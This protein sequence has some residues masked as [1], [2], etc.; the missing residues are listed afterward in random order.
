MSAFYFKLI[1]L[2][3]SALLVAL[4]LR[5]HERYWDLGF[6][7]WRRVYAGLAV[8]FLGTLLGLLFEFA[9]IK[10]LQDRLGWPLDWLLFGA[11]TLVGAWLILSGSFERLARLQGER[12]NLDRERESYE[13]INAI[14]E[15]ANGSYSLVEILDYS[16]KEFIGATEA[17]A[18]VVWL[19]HH[20]NNE[21]ILASS[22]GLP[23][24]VQQQSERI[25]GDDVQFTRILEHGRARAVQGSESVRALLPGGDQLRRYEYALAFPMINPTVSE[26][27]TPILGL[28]ILFASIPF[29]STPPKK[30]LYEAALTFL[31]RCIERSFLKRMLR[32]RDERQKDNQHVLEQFSH[33]LSAWSVERNPQRQLRLAISGLAEHTPHFIG[34]SR[35]HVDDDRWEP[36]AMAGGAKL[37]SLLGDPAM[38]DAAAKTVAELSEQEFLPATSA[39]D[40]APAVRYRLI[41][42]GIDL[43]GKSAQGI[44]F[45]PRED[46]LPFWWQWAETIICSLA[47]MAFTKEPQSKGLSMGMDLPISSTTKPQSSPT[48]PITKTES[49]FAKETE[50]TPARRQQLDQAMLTWLANQDPPRQLGRIDFSADIPALF[51][52]DCAQFYE[53]LWWALATFDSN[54][55][56]GDTIVDLQYDHGHLTV[57]LALAH[58]E[59]L[60]PA[61]RLPAASPLEPTDPGVREIMQVWRGRARVYSAANGIVRLLLSITPPPATDQ[62]A[63][64]TLPFSILVVDEE[65]LIRDLLVGMV[66][67]LGHR[68]SPT[69]SAATGLREF[70]TDHFDVLIVSQK[71]AAKGK[72]DIV[73]QVHEFNP[74]TKVIVIREQGVLDKSPVPGAQAT[75]LKPFRLEDLRSVL[76]D[77]LLGR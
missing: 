59:S 39:A 2:V 60:H 77:T 53:L 7:G 11:C 75:L 67:M 9:E 20:K 1:P 28:A 5:Y 72:E 35:Y 56:D 12:R 47:E 34:C 52:E 6:L 66:E 64:R 44:V 16:L 76:N 55:G 38:R 40:D 65:E 69:T 73:T 61:R 68:A 30:R 27:D 48:P 23:L 58:S 57:G 45:L 74:H 13:I 71:I 51:G 3:A 70:F 46:S 42:V 14:R 36:L 18:G 26:A 24:S 49:V 62:R 37:E 19:Y 43:A 50:P 8:V 22:S 29:A 15:V 21:Y 63:A 25:E 10:S 4:A 54:R 41:P 31:V 32:E 33:W 17:E